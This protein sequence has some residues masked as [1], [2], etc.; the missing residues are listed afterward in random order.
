MEHEDRF[1]LENV[2]ISDCNVRE[3]A[4]PDS[5]SPL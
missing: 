4:L 2:E 5:R 1:E 3:A